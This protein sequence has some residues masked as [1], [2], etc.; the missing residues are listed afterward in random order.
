MSIE[1]QVGV[2][3]LIKFGEYAGWQVLVKDDAVNSGGF[4]ILISRN[5][6]CL[7]S[8]GFDNWVADKSAVHSYFAESKW[9]IEWP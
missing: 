7:Q 6:S 5:F 4:L 1:I 9:E 8:E 3:G 2:T